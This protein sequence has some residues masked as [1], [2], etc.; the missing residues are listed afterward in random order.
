MSSDTRGKYSSTSKSVS[1][2]SR[3]SSRSD[4]EFKQ[5][6]KR[7]KKNVVDIENVAMDQTKFDIKVL[8]RQ[9][10]KGTESGSTSSVESRKKSTRNEVSK[11]KSPLFESV[12]VPLTEDIGLD[13]KITKCDSK[14]DLVSGQYI[15]HISKSI[16]PEHYGRHIKELIFS[17]H[18]QNVSNQF[19]QDKIVIFD[20]LLG[21]IDFSNSSS[22]SSITVLEPNKSL[23]LERK[24][25]L[26]NEDHD[27]VKILSNTYVAKRLSSGSPGIR[28]SNIATTVIAR[29]HPKIKLSGEF[30][31]KSGITTGFAS[32]HSDGYILD[33]TVDRVFL[34]IHLKNTGTAPLSR[35][36]VGFIKV[37]KGY[38][39][40]SRFIK[41]VKISGAKGIWEVS[42]IGNN[43]CAVF[44][45]DETLYPVGSGINSTVLS[46]VFS[47]PIYDKQ[48]R[49]ITTIAG[50]DRL[51]EKDIGGGT[52][53]QDNWIIAPI[54]KNHINIEQK[55]TFPI[56]LNR[57]PT[58]IE[59]SNVDDIPS[60]IHLSIAPIYDSQSL[61]LEDHQSG[62]SKGIIRIGILLN[63][64]IFG[65]RTGNYTTLQTS[66][67]NS[68]IFFMV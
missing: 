32:I 44:T 34:N 4:R 35:P 8:S 29:G 58:T 1:S 59:V 42:S 7:P 45:F 57:I 64:Y 67:S 18:I 21:V 49:M 19:F 43:N 66:L 30:S 51:Y 48:E 23:Y 31:S 15:L 28:T 46:V 2:S 16:T 5:D 20:S 50:I 24:Y 13:C 39:N 26:T 25:F 68:D 27:K 6:L 10:P 52:E 40:I 41:E 60:S 63:V 36:Q 9:M 3:G 11:Y 12:K 38:A 55:I 17:Y 65:L 61:I 56:I 14:P 33:P 22:R 47:F 53:Y 54:V 62:P 37:P